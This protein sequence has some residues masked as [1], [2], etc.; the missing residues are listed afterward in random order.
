M[1]EGGAVVDEAVSPAFG[2][3]RVYVGVSAVK[4][5]LDEEGIATVQS[6]ALPGAQAV[7]FAGG[8]GSETA[9]QFNA[10]LDLKIAKG[11]RL[12]GDTSYLTGG[13][14]DAFRGSGGFIVNW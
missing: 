5:L 2:G 10:G 1:G 7:S 6:V 11:T 13:D 14:A 9:A 8:F 4:D 12:Y 3:S